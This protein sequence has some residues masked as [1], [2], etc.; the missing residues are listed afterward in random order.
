MANLVSSSGAGLDVR[1]SV[2]LL[3]R[4]SHLGVQCD[5]TAFKENIYERH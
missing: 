2:A 1:P 3:F 5:Y 4:F